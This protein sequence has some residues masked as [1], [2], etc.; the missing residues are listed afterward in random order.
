MGHPALQPHAYLRKGTAKLLT[1]FHPATGQVRVKGVLSSANVVWHPW[2]Q[3]DMHPLRRFALA[4]PEQPPLH[5]LERIGLQ[6]DQE[7]QPPILRGRQR[8]VLV[9][10]VAA[11]GT[12]L[13]LEAPMGHMGLE[14][15]LKGRHQRPKLGHGETGQI[16]DRRRPGLELGEPSSAHG[17]GLRSSETQHTI[18]RD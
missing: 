17:G 15:G 12:R 18:N 9:G 4:H 8:T 10:R 7:K 5:H 3:A 14:R 11:G 16:Q 2:R 6:V 13:P 1:L